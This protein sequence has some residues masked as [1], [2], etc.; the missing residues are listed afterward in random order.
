MEGKLREEY[1]PFFSQNSIAS[2]FDENSHSVVESG[3]P[4]KWKRIK[5]AYQHL[6]DCK[7]K[8]FIGFDEHYGLITHCV[9]LPGNHEN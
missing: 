4:L 5:L 3:S 6:F 7:L 2:S 9:F 1:T 8:N